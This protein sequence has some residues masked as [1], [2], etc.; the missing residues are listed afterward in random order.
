M[1]SPQWCA[2]QTVASRAAFRRSCEIATLGEQTDIRIQPPARQP[3]EK[4]PARAG[5]KG[6]CPRAAQSAAGLRAAPPVPRKHPVLSPNGFPRRN[7]PYRLPASFMPPRPTP[8]I[9]KRHSIKSRVLGP[10]PVVGTRTHSNAWARYSELI[11]A[12]LP[13][14][15]AS[16][17]PSSPLLAAAR[18]WLAVHP[19]AACSGC[20]LR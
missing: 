7:R 10:S 11:G 14:P 13:P 17:P 6:Y 9:D 19:L 8:P 1:C 4:R 5:G 3:E 15:P 2:A 18:A 20:S 16:P 12:K